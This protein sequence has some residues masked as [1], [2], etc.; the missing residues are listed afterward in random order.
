MLLGDVEPAEA[1][2]DLG[3]ARRPPQRAVAVPDPV[4]DV[5]VGGAAQAAGDGLLERGREVGLDRV[6]AGR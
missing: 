4:H 6:R 1:V 2:G 5:L 3:R